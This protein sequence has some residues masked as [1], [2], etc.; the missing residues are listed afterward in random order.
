MRPSL[1][2]AVA[3]PNLVR[4]QSRAAETGQRANACALFAANQT[5]DGCTGAGTNG[6]RQFVTVLLP[7]TAALRRG[8]VIVIDATG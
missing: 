7:K 5:T 6:Q 8:S 3:L 4:V 1:V 2:I